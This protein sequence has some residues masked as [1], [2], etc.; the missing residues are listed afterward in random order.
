VAIQ[1][2]LVLVPGQRLEQ[3]EQLWLHAD[4][5]IVDAATRRELAR[6][7]FRAGVV[8]PSPPDGMAEL[9][10]LDPSPETSSSPWQA[11]P[12]DKAP[13]VTGHLHHRPP[14]QRIEIQASAVYDE[15]PLF[16]G[17]D[18]G[19]TGKIMERAQGLYA[20]KWSPLPQGRVQIEVTPE[21]HYGQPKTQYAP[22]EGNEWRYATARMKEVFEKLRIQVPLSAGQMLVISSDPRAIGSLGHH[23][24][25][26]SAPDGQQHRLVVIRLVQVPEA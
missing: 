19:L 3:L 9:L 22:G 18:A 1:T 7:G 20:L 2:L 6:N 17:G 16:V 25:T 21:L 26:L 13:T 12:L 23:F 8:G 15:L 24:H 11:Q 5:Q 4:E 10:E 14:N